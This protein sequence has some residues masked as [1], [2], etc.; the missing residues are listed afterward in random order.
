MK[1]FS[2]I[3]CILVALHCAAAEPD[4]KPELGAM[5]PGATV[6]TIIK[7]GVA[8]GMAEPRRAQVY[9]M[10]MSGRVSVTIRNGLRVK[11]GDTL[12]V[13]EEERVKAGKRKFDAER[14]EADTARRMQNLEFRRKVT[15]AKRTLEETESYATIAEKR[16][17][18]PS[19]LNGAAED[20]RKILEETNKR[21]VKQL[22]DECENL[23]ES[24]RLMEESEVRSA[25]SYESRVEQA[26]IDWENIE[27]NSVVRADFSGIATVLV[28]DL[29]DAKRE[30]VFRAQSSLVVVED[31][32]T[33]QV[34]VQAVSQPWAELR[35]ERLFV[36]PRLPS[37]QAP[38]ADFKEMRPGRTPDAPSKYTFI[39]PAGTALRQLHGKPIA[40]DIYYKLGAPHQV[41]RK[42]ELYKY[43]TGLDFS[44]LMQSFNSRHPEWVMSVEGHA[45]CAIFPAALIKRK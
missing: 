14:D 4:T 29:L 6:S 15:E 10:P 18:D 34:Q 37:G 19:L 24:I 33:T 2:T 3:A 32:H 38:V 28:E 12:F 5:F 39:F 13:V 20:T 30:A 25:K 8:E 40:Y 27:R 7:A 23:R 31:D 42:S 22:K 36:A 21:G 44:H 16:E 11:P 45:E 41:V 1:H 9:D 26:R 35:T 17:K 43:D